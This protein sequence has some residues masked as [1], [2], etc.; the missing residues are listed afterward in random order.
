MHLKVQYVQP[1]ANQAGN[2]GHSSKMRSW[3]VGRVL[4]SESVDELTGSIWVLNA[5]RWKKNLG[6]LNG[7]Q[8]KLENHVGNFYMIYMCTHVD[9]QICVVY[10]ICLNLYVYVVKHLYT[11]NGQLF[12]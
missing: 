12:T 7:L 3:M 11:C 6:P 8:M 2:P 9:I 4:K 10:Y 1:P 5:A